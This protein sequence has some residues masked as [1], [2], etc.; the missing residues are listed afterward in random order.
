M[1]N[2]YT[3][4]STSKNYTCIC[5]CF[6]SGEVVEPSHS[7]TSLLGCYHTPSSMIMDWTSKTFYFSLGP[8]IRQRQDPFGFC[9]HREL[10]ASHQEHLH[11]WEQRV[12]PTFL[13]Q[14]T[15]LMA[16]KHTN[17]EDF[18]DRT[19]PVSDCAGVEPIPQ[20]PAPNSHG[21]DSWTLWSAE[22]SESSGETFTT[23][24]ISGPK[25]TCLVNSGFKNI[26]AVSRRNK[27]VFAYAQNWIEPNPQLLAPTFHQEES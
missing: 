9:L 6:P 10:K 16:S 5:S 23:S 15:L 8:R 4:F 13:L 11:T 24:H 19:L 25:V 21:W 27:L 26:R 17:V 2:I 18:W 7:W 14:A 1:D 22:N 20:H 3:W 12:K